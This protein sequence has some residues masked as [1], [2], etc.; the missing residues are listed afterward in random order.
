MNKILELL[1]NHIVLMTP[2]LVLG[3]TILFA[4]WVLGRLYGRI[5]NRISRAADDERKDVWNLVRRTGKV[6]LI[7]FGLIT[8]LGTMGI[9]VTA[10]VA[11]LGLTGFA[12][13]FALKDALSNI[14]AGVLIM[15]YQPFRRN[16]CIAVGGFQG[17]VTAIDL[18][19]TTIKSE[20]KRILIPNSALFTDKIVIMDNEEMS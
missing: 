14:L 20:G 10:L 19:Y 16:D 12:L 17:K 7:L 3:L 2:K 9:N 5:I 13:G 1:T 11:G 18:R 6:L 8:A 15:V 4:F